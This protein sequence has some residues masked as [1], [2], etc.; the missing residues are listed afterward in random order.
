MFTTPR[1][2]LLR[3][4]RAMVGDISESDL[5]GDC[6]VLYGPKATCC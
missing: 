6:A 1:H 5:R 3:I 2:P 4:F